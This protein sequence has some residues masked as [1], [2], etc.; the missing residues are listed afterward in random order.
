[1]KENGSKKMMSGGGASNFRA[2][3]SPCS[4]NQSIVDALLVQRPLDNSFRGA[5]WRKYLNHLM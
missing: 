3:K 1:M 5:A 2:A 4:S